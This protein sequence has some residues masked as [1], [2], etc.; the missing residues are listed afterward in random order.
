MA[1]TDIAQ[2]IR[3]KAIK[4][5][6]KHNPLAT[7][8]ILAKEFNVSINTIRLDR[9]H[10]G[11]KE[12]KER[13]KQQ[14]QQSM[15]H[16]QSISEKEFFGDLIEFQP[17]VFAKSRLEIKEH[18][19]FNNMNVAKGQFIYSF[20]ETLAISLIPTPA[21]L[22]GVANIKYI[23]KIYSGDIIYAE[24]IIKRK[25]DTGYLVWVYIKDEK[26]DLKFKGK[27]ILKGIK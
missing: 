3:R 25:T 22:V 2:K 5:F 6:L 27:F 4:D 12:F 17:E 11:I 16:V 13:L 21:A 15:K 14:A 8:S 9:S 1:R 19:T 10:L 23:K 24:A 20:A 7:D 18:M 26:N